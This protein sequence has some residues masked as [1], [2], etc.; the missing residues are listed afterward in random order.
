M[1]HHRIVV[2]QLLQPK[3]ATIAILDEMQEQPGRCKEG[4]FSGQSAQTAFCVL[5]HSSR[6]LQPV[7]YFLCCN[8]VSSAV[9]PVYKC[10]VEYIVCKLFADLLNEA[11]FNGV[12]LFTCREISKS[13]KCLLKA[14]LFV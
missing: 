1:I 6:L 4:I 14:R 9:L 13:T 11:R 7:M 2:V 8:Q 12:Q 5:R 10:F 3:V